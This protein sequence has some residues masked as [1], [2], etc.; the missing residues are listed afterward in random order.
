VRRVL[1][2]SQETARVLGIGAS[3]A[4]GLIARARADEAS[5]GRQVALALRQAEPSHQ[6]RISL[7]E[8]VSPSFEAEERHETSIPG[9]YAGGDLVT[10]RQAAVIAAA[11]GMQAA[12]MLNHE[13]AID[14]AAG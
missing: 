6:K 4:C 14:L 7:S 8:T 3:V 5:S 2:R 13:L 1:T 12:A 9:I 10:P 11:S